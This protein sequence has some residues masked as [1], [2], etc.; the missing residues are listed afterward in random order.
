MA[1]KQTDQVRPSRSNDARRMQ[2]SQLIS[3]AAEVR[4]LASH[5][6]VE[7]WFKRTESVF[8]EDVLAAKDEHTRIMAV[9]RVH[10]LRDLR[11]YLAAID[12]AAE[13]AERRLGQ[14]EELE[15]QAN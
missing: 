9:A 7:K 14:M 5:C 10:V 11:S 13:N 12:S 6:E 3:E 15:R 4:A 8:V 1:R 2:L